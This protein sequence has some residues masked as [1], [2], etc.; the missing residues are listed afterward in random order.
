MAKLSVKKI[1]YDPFVPQFS[2]VL[3]NKSR[4]TKYRLESRL[5]LPVRPVDFYGTTVYLIKGVTYSP[6]LKSFMARKS[7]NKKVILNT[8]RF[9][10]DA[11]P[12]AKV[13]EIILF[14]TRAYIEA[15]ENLST[16]T[17]VVDTKSIS[18]SLI[19]KENSTL[20]PALRVQFSAQFGKNTSR[21]IGIDKIQKYEQALQ[22]IAQFND[23]V[24]VFKGHDNDHFEFRNDALPVEI[25][26]VESNEISKRLTKAFDRYFKKQG[27]KVADRNDFNDPS[28]RFVQCIELI[29]QNLTHSVPIKTSSSVDIALRPQRSTGVVGVKFNL[30]RRNLVLYVAAITGEKPGGFHK[31][32]KFY[33]SEHK[34]DTAFKMA[35][36]A[37]HKAYSLP[38]PSRHS[39]LKDLNT[40][41][42]RLVMVV[43][44]PLL[45]Q[46]SDSLEGISVTYGKRDKRPKMIDFSPIEA[47]WL[48]NKL[49]NGGRFKGLNHPNRRNKNN[50]VRIDDIELLNFDEDLQELSD[51]PQPK[52]SNEMNYVQFSKNAYSEDEIKEAYSEAKFLESEIEKLTTLHI[53]ALDEFKDAG[54][55]Y[56]NYGGD[57]PTFRIMT[58]DCERC[59]AKSEFIESNGSFTVKCTSCT[60]KSAKLHSE[61]R[62]KLDWNRK[63]AHT[64]KLS[65]IPHFHLKN[66]AIATSITFME[67]VE[68]L[69][70]SEIDKMHAKR[71][72][73]LLQRKYDLKLSQRYS[74]P[75]KQFIEKLEAYGEWYWITMEVLNRYAL[76]GKKWNQ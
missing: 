23:Q 21:S 70:F 68:K 55:R 31:E 50:K 76:V 30:D 40:F 36:E 32:K 38:A 2:T 27:I 4:N 6:A 73:A 75:G 48:R 58:A 71:D 13:A 46:V 61:W 66:R 74:K 67:S 49:R 69:L 20:W 34:L 57:S 22:F 7:V 72:L 60:H 47:M 39:Y 26:D 12:K 56:G 3:D 45:Y 53:S 29:K 25:N 51:A 10:N 44:Q 65:D 24:K 14:L 41:K 64:V 15:T 11:T 43:P 35:K 37:F 52:L 59:G 1:V 8:T 33:L 5:N 42:A 9:A 18:I 54:Y 62:A 63:N 28:E 19:P 16:D 17:S